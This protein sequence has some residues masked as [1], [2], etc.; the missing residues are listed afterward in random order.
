[1]KGLYNGSYMRVFRLFPRNLV[2]AA[3]LSPSALRRLSW[4][5]WYQVHNKNISLTCRH[6]GISRDTFYLW[7]KRF[8]PRNLRSLEDDTSNRRPK[9]VRQMTTPKWIQDLTCTIRSNEP[10]KSKYEIQ[11]E[12]KDLYQVRIGYNTVQKVINRHPELL[13]VKADHKKGVRKHRSYSI[14]RLRAAYELKDKYPGALVQI[15]TKH[16]YVLGKRFYLLVAVDCKSRLG[17]VRCYKTGSSLNTADFLLRVIRYFPFKIE[18][19]N[20]DNGSENLLN[21]HKLCVSLS[22]THFFSYP[23]TPKMNSRVE[24]LIQTVTYEFFNWQDD[25]LDNIDDINQRCDIFNEKYNTKR[26]HGAI[27]YKTPIQ[28][29]TMLL[30]QQ[31]KG[32]QLYGM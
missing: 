21:F 14:S 27:G 3:S 17:F 4:F 22:I 13:R 28:Y 32:E 31:Q 18:S 11:A 23:H 8:N 12:L 5:D 9:C 10:E 24:R 2:I 25:L 26:Y 1:M 30:S 29:L 16:L 15:D 20:T 6:F 19:V 7:R